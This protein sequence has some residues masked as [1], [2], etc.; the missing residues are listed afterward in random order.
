MGW[1]IA[2]AEDLGAP[3]RPL[4]AS[5]AGVVAQENGDVNAPPPSAIVAA[6]SSALLTTSVNDEPSLDDDGSLV[7]ALPFVRVAT[8]R[9]PSSR[10]VARW[11]RRDSTTASDA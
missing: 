7:R 5:S 4:S 9:S 3:L 1:T 11:R 6:T 8:D 10:S 2:G